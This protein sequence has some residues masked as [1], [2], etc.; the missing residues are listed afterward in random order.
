MRTTNAK[1]WEMAVQRKPFKASNIF[2]EMRG[3]TYVVYSYDYH[4]PLYVNKDGVWYETNAKYSR[5][6]AKHWSQARPTFNTILTTI[7]DIK[8]LIP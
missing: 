5:S 7:D 3:S 6:T 4:W 8:K 2:A 1:C